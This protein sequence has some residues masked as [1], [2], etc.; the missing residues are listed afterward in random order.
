MLHG[1]AAVPQSIY[2]AAA[3]GIYI[4]QLEFKDA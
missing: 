1:G 3:L 4:M 2:G